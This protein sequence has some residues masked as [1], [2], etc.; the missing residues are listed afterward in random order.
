MSFGVTALGFV[1]KPLP[2]IVTD[3]GASLQAAPSFG[4]GVDLDPSG[5]LGQ[6]VGVLASPLADLWQAL[7]AI[8]AAQYPD[9]ASDTSLD[10]VMSLSGALRLAPQPSVA[11]AVL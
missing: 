8:Y 11:L 10:N 5:P 1:V 3:L 9:S 2:Q 6:L 4:A 7:Q